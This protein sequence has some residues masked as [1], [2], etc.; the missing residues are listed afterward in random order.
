MMGG[1]PMMG[2]GPQPGGMNGLAIAS[3]ITGILSIPGCCCWPVG[4][5]LAVTACILGIIG[6][7]KIKASNG[8]QRGG[9]MAIAGIVCGGI[10]LIL[11]LLALLTTIDDALKSRGGF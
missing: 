8:A 6:L 4:A 7:M 11:M 5:A 1:P 3:M 9:G 10:G 2:A